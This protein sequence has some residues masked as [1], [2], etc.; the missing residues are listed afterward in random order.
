MASQIS[1][2]SCVYQLYNESRCYESSHGLVISLEI[3]RSECSS[4]GDAACD[5]SDLIISNH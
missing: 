2:G 1:E 3:L 5:D 4:N